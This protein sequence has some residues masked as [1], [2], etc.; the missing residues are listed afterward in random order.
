[1]NNSELKKNI[2]TFAREC[3]FSRAAV[4]PAQQ[5]PTGDLFRRYI[6]NGYHGEMDYLSRDI[7][8]RLDP[9]LLMEGAR[10][11]ICLAATCSPD[12]E[13]Y[14]SPV[15][16]FYRGR[17]YHRVLKKRA[18]CL[19]N[20]IAVEIGDF[21]SRICVDSAPAAERSLA[22]VSGL[23]WIGKNGMLIVP[24]TGNTVVL[25]EIVTDLVLEPDKPLE[26]Q[27]GDCRDCMEA[28]PT[29]AILED[30]FVDSRLCISYHTIENRERIPPELRSAMGSS[31]FGCDRCRNVCPYSR[32]GPSGDPD[33]APAGFP[34]PSIGEILS[35]DEPA[36]DRATRGTALRRARLRMF[37]RNAAIAA[38]NSGDKSLVPL[39]EDLERCNG[40]VEEIEWAIAKLK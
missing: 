22:A 13:N 9:S 17:D 40:P 27:C 33:L 14:D 6:E 8:K 32:S 36:W 21:N 23:G 24:G 34:T 28:C 38:G 1:M 12:K 30:G 15:S 2:R 20:R 26:S 39:L 4:A 3:G 16:C 37:H 18:V 25:A 10:S 31:V 7:D 19:C 11:V 29:G 35:W 5:V